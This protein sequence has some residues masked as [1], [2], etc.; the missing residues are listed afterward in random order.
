MKKTILFAALAACLAITPSVFAGTINLN[1][2]DAAALDALDGIGAKKAEAIIAYRTTH[3]EF[4]TLDTLKDVPG[5]GEKLFEKIAPS[6]S[7]TDDATAPAATAA[8]DSKA[9]TPTAAASTT[10]TANTATDNKTST[11]AATTSDTKATP[12][13]TTGDKAAG[14]KAKTENN[15]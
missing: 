5:I 11:P 15:T 7:L 4:K 9:S 3:G 1:K 14:T 10:P 6:L 8:T 2:A 13:A 12:A